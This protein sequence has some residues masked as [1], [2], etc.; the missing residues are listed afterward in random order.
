MYRCINGD[1]LNLHICVASH[2]LHV[3]FSFTRGITWTEHSHKHSI[4]QHQ[5]DSREV[6]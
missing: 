4:T 5:A 6:L 1:R 2:G 3:N